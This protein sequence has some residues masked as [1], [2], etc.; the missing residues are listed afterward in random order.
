MMLSQQTD[1]IVAIATA[2]G[3]GAIGVVR[4]SGKNLALLVRALCGTT[5]KPREATYLPF[6][7]SDGTPIDHGLAIFFEAPHSFTGEDVLELQAHGGPVILQMLLKRC[8]Q[9]ARETDEKTANPRLPGL[10]I[11]KPGEFSERAFLNNKLDLAQAEAIADLID[12]STEAAAISASRSLAGGFSKQI[13]VLR[14]GLIELRKLVEATLDFPEEEIDFLKKADAQGQLGRLLSKLAQVRQ[15]AK[16]GSLLREGIKVV[17]AG[18]PN[19]GKSS[20]LNALA[21]SDLAIVTPMA[22]TTRDK[23]QQTIQ[24]EGVPVHIIDTAGL[25]DGENEVE[26][27]GIERTWTEVKGADVV[28]FLHDLTRYEQPQYQQSENEIA[29]NLN[30]LVQANV[31]VLDIW[32]KLD[33]KKDFLDPTGISLSAKTGEGLELLQKKLLALAGW[34]AAPEGVFMARQ[35]H[36]NGL[37]KVAQNLENA[38]KKLL[39]QTLELDLMAEDLRLAQNALNE[40]TGE[41]T[42]EDLLGEIF[43]SFCIGK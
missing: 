43:S 3:R 22:G 26:K 15:E 9:A 40:I 35:R 5:L 27:I 21:G 42:N 13:Q 20:L 31:P 34:R 7:A 32:N 23:I 30:K 11:A 14:Q 17:I 36:I 29:K 28:L 16:Q 8:L 39:S 18:Q 2:P 1:P 19:A 41:F 25:R 33:A 6:R 37:L 38:W 4:V 12:A 24:I 10:R